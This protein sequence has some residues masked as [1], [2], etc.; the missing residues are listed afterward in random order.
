M[1]N[2]NIY[3]IHEDTLERIESKD[4]V[5]ILTYNKKTFDS[6]FNEK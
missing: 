4:N 1:L 3:N 5:F 6:E 2:K